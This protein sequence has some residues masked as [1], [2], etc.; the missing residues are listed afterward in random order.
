M[1]VC[2][3]V[4]CML[5][6]FLR[7]IQ[8]FLKHFCADVPGIILC[9]LQNKNLQHVT[10][11]WGSFLGI[12]ELFSILSLFSWKRRSRFSHDNLLTCSW[13]YSDINYTRRNFSRSVPPRLDSILASFG[14][15]LRFVQCFFIKYFQCFLI[16]YSLY[17]RHFGGFLV[18]FIVCSLNSREPSNIFVWSF[19][20][21]P[22][23]WKIKQ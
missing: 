7:I 5:H 23:F 3:Q 14:S 19:E 8:C 10:L 1:A 11:Y 13:Y 21:Y 2:L 16:K 22:F 17:L 6:Y 15:F 18:Y 12:Y 4:V 20:H 9:S